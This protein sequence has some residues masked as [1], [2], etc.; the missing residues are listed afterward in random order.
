ML[1]EAEA[2]TKVCCGPPQTIKGKEPLFHC[3]GAACMA[4][5][6]AGEFT[7]RTNCGE[8]EKPHPSLGDGWVSNP[9]NKGA[10][11]RGWRRTLRKGY[12]GLASTPP[13]PE[14]R[15]EFIMPVRA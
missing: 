9:M 7:Q 2:A 12:C 8:H 4:W 1:T 15:D 3:I 6:D 10:A 13:E 5:R 14:E 11:A